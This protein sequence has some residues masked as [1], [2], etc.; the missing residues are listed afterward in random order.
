MQYR[1]PVGGIPPQA[2]GPAPVKVRRPLPPPQPI[3][4]V[5]EDPEEDDGPLSRDEVARLQNIPIISPAPPQQVRVFQQPQRVEEDEEE[6]IPVRQ[7][8]QPIQFR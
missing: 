5:V 8:P 4:P 1:R 6:N 3:R 2:L 7:Q